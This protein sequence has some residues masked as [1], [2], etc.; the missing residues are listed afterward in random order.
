MLEKAHVVEIVLTGAHCALGRGEPSNQTVQT[1][2]LSPALFGLHEAQLGL[3]DG[4][5]PCLVRAV[6]WALLT[7]TSAYQ[8]DLP[9]SSD[10]QSAC[11]QHI[12][13][14]ALVELSSL[15]LARGPAAAA[16]WRAC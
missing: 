1:V 14:A 7:E 10:W 6:G 8:G 13:H 4:L 15:G 2:R 16:P 11:A 3:L 5:E 12:G 9:V